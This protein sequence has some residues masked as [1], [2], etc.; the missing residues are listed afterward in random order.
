MTR[1]VLKKLNNL[2]SNLLFVGQI[3]RVPNYELATDSNIT[4]IVKKGDTLYSI[5]LKYDTSVN[6]IIN[7]NNLIDK[8]KTAQK[9]LEDL[10]SNYDTVTA[11]ETAA[12]NEV[13]RLLSSTKEDLR[14]EIADNTRFFN[15]YDGKEDYATF[16]YLLDKLNTIYNK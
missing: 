4:Y 12:K 15:D 6:S 1:F 8:L 5:S 11:K 13:D 14:E 9:K 3:L 16:Y 7:R 2:N 10:N